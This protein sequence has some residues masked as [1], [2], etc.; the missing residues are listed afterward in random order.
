MMGYVLAI[1]VST[2]ES[3]YSRSG[4]Y[5]SHDPG[6]KTFFKLSKSR[7]RQ[8]VEI[9][10]LNEIYSNH[11]CVVVIMSPNHALVPLFR[12]L[13][14]FKIVFDA[15][16][17]LSDST[18]FSNGLRSKIR[19]VQN[20]LIDFIAFKM[21]HEIIL[22]SLQQQSAVVTR[23]K[24]SQEKVHSLFT[25]FNEEES[26]SKLLVE[27]RPQECERI[28]LLAERFVLF[29]GKLNSESGLSII[30]EAARILG[31]D[32]RVVIL[33]NRNIEY[34]PL[35]IILINRFVSKA[36]ITWL[37][38]NATCVIGQISQVE[39]LR[40]TLPH[41]LFEAAYYSKCYVS[42]PHSG[43]L[44]FLEDSSFIPVESVDEFGLKEALE[45]ALSS[46]DLRTRCEIKINQMYK[47]RA[48]PT[49]LSNK[50]REII[51]RKT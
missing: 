4:L 34:I 10:K 15:G 46:G 25:G 41:K 33:T 42:P 35:N 29:R 19:F 7:V 28:D 51:E 38:R 50:F 40:K 11:A 32:V 14:R 22:E 9:R 43:I 17:P 20:H 18:S 27:K 2:L 16:W 39:R 49:I 23:F 44:E 45:L 36:E 31:P 26:D 1:Y 13:T 48:S 37:Y 47:L 30:I 21:S 5:Y 12:L 6:E 24:I 3:D 8:I